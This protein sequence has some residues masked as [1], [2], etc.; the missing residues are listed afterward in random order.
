MATIYFIR[1]PAGSIFNSDKANRILQNSLY[2]GYVL[3]ICIIFVHKIF[4]EN[5]KLLFSDFLEIVRP[6]G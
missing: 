2:C 3:S 6:A 5:F 1:R 4:N